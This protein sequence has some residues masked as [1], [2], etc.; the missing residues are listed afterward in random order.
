MIDT[1]AASQGYP[2]S[3]A[4]RF[5]VVFLIAAAL[6]AGTAVTHYYV[7]MRTE[8]IE[9]ETSELLNVELG[10]TAIARDL[11]S[12]TSDLMFLARHNELQGMFESDNRKLWEMLAK[13]FL[14]FI[15]QKGKYDQI[16]FLDQ[17]GMELVRVNYNDGNPTIVPEDQLQN[18]TH[19][20]YF[21]K[22]WALA[23]DGVYI[24]PMDLNIE[25]GQIEQ[26]PK[27]MIR[28]GTPVFDR[29]GRKRGIFLFNYLGANLIRDFKRAAANISDHVML[30]NSDGFWLSSPRRDDEW[31]FM[32][33]NDRTFATAHPDAWQRIQAG[34]SGQFHN[35]E[36]MFSF[37][38][39][40]PLLHAAGDHRPVGRI[41]SP[42]VNKGYYWKA[43]SRVSPQ[44]LTT[45]PHY[46]F[47]RHMLLYAAMLG[48]LALA[49][50]LLARATV[51]HQ[52]AATQ[53]ELERRVRGSLE[54]KVEERTR[55]LKDTQA[56]KDRVVQQ[57]IQA[58]KMAAIGTMASGIGHEINNPLY[59]ILGMAEAIRDEEDISRCRGYGRDIIKQSRRIAEIVRNLSGY[60][61]PAA[62]HDLEPVDVNETL[63]EA[64]S[65][66]RRSLLSDHVEIRENLM[67]VSRLSAKSEEIQQAFFNVIRNGMQAMKGRGILEI[68]SRQEGNRVWI[69]IRDTGVGIPAE[70]LGKIYDPF[71]TTKGPD[72]GEG[73]GLYIVQQIVNK[74]AGTITLESKEG[75][76]TV[77]TIQFPVGEKN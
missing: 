12:V 48:L 70:H 56:E 68:T 67:P 77:C 71:F 3:V 42:V 40:Y 61:R 51:R 46:F 32:Y 2:W 44:L 28:F 5:L 50:A 23:R 27:P 9:R 13:Q 64:V 35:E 30:L 52:Q 36:G 75:R 41:G 29:S 54:G 59:A 76:G 11:E 26:P 38:T 22:T 73:L 17:T 7:G 1:A 16:R 57:L 53:V 4:K 15:T 47:R 69:R 43:V 37:T 25:H 14:V 66:A 62:E 24:S 6:L 33:D 21:G 55:E 65:M 49:S 34:E 18:K 45:T 19:R 31:G 60:V 10:K 58:E 74:Y 20:Y 63:S 8:R 72:E 39:V